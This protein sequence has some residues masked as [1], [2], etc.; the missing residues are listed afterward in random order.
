MKR[1][2]LVVIGVLVLAVVV[3]AGVVG[4]GG[5]TDDEPEQRGGSAP[6]SP[7]PSAEGTTAA[8]VAGKGSPLPT[9]STPPAGTFAMADAAKLG[10]DARYAI[11]FSPYGHGP[12]AG[13]QTFVIHV[14]T[15][16][17]EN[18]SARA[19]SFADRN[20]LVYLGQGEAP[21]QTG[22]AYTAVLGFRADGALLVPVVSTVRPAE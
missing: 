5:T 8:H 12:G 1:R 17:P 16:T 3:V 9:I 21:L 15:A 19:M 6:S 14:S 13:G 20:M 7:A 2:R 4:L 18:E 10:A 22:G 11:T